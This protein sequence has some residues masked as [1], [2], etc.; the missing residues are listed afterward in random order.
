[1]ANLMS[2]RPPEELRRTLKEYAKRKG[3]TV[4]QLV[5]QILWE[6]TEKNKIA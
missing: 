5:T 2:I 1:M 4:N 6:W 3:Y